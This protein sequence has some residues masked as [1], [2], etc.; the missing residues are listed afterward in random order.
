MDIINN[1]KSGC[2]LFS[3]KDGAFL[4][5]LWCF[6]EEKKRTNQHKEGTNGKTSIG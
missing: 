6:S 4:E 1:R 5:V 3:E 2:Y